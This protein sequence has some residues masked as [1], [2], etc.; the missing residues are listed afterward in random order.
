MQ[1]WETWENTPLHCCECC[2]FIDMVSEE[3]HGYIGAYTLC[4]ACHRNH[5]DEISAEAGQ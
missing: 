4:E 2:A 3:N 1:R 5:L